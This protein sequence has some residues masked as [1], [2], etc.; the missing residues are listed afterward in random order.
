M[1]KFIAHM[2][3]VA[4]IVPEDVTGIVILLFSSRKSQLEIIVNRREDEKTSLFFLIRVKLGSKITPR[5]VCHSISPQE[6]EEEKVEEIQLK[7]PFS[8]QR[9]QNP[10]IRIWRR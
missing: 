4:P 8:W 10:P 9:K 1:H 5:T 7:E 3:N 6:G 2:N